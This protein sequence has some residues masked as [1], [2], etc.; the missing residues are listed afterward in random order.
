MQALFS[1][2]LTLKLAS[3]L[4]NSYISDKWK[5]NFELRY[6]EANNTL[7]TV[8][9][10]LQ[11]RICH[12]RSC[13]AAPKVSLNTAPCYSCLGFFQRLQCNFLSC[14]VSTCTLPEDIRLLKEEGIRWETVWSTMLLCAS[15]MWCWRVMLPWNGAGFLMFQTVDFNECS[16]IPFINS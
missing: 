12:A 1:H 10:L 11:S 16:K 8:F 13:Q 6:F 7:L 15:L 4:L 2:L 3:E 5:I 14:H 9:L